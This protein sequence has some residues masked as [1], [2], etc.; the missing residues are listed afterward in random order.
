MLPTLLIVIL[1]C[2]MFIYYSICFTSKYREI[3]YLS[4]S[5]QEFTQERKQIQITEKRIIIA[6]KIFNQTG[7][8]L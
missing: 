2:V 8:L 5:T 3:L 4:F 7:D 6:L 1:A